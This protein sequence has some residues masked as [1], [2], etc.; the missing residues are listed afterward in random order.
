MCLGL[1]CKAEA[2][3]FITWTLLDP[4]V[5]CLDSFGQPPLSLPT[6]VKLPV[7]YCWFPSRSELLITLSY[8]DHNSGL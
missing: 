6:D 1:G 4:D 7:A 3:F 5:L 8:D 2:S